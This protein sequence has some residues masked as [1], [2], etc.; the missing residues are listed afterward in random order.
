MRNWDKVMKAKAHH[1]N[2]V[3][4]GAKDED[5]YFEFFAGSDRVLHTHH[6]I[7]AG[8]LAVLTYLKAFHKVYL[9]GTAIKLLRQQFE[10]RSH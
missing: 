10:P 6:A 5:V 2:F 4:R 9:E 8:G 7:V 1:R 3:G